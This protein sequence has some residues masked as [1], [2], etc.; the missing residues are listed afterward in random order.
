M[1]AKGRMLKVCS[2]GTPTSTRSSDL[3]SEPLRA[4][5]YRADEAV[6]KAKLTA[7]QLRMISDF[8]HFNAPHVSDNQHVSG[9][10]KQ[11]E[12]SDVRKRPIK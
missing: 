1:A 8:V 3:S 6:Q 4:A 5:R 7:E 2:W 12:D 11:A 9:R 10:S